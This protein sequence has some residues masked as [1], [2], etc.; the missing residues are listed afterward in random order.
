MSSSSSSWLINHIRGLVVLGHRAVTWQTPIPSVSGVSAFS[1]YGRTQ[2]AR[3][4][5]AVTNGRGAMGIADTPQTPH[6]TRSQ[7]LFSF[8]RIRG[9][10]RRFLKP[11][12]ENRT[13]VEVL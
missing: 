7:Q 2:V 8:I 9:S 10:L 12:L 1:G 6:S 3:Y 5:S 11:S 13:V 4:D